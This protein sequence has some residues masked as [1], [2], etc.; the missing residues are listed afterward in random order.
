VKESLTDMNKKLSIFDTKILVVRSEI[1]KVLQV[2]QQR[3]KVTHIFSQQETGIDVTY[4]RDKLFK[5]YCDQNLIT[6][7]ESVSNGV[8]RGLQNRDTWNTM[9]ENYM[10]ESILEFKPKKKQL[11]NLGEIKQIGYQFLIPKLET[12]KNNQFQKGGTEEGL[13]Y[14]N[15]FFESKKNSDPANIFVPHNSNYTGGRISPYLA[16]GNLSTREVWNVA[17]KVLAKSNHSEAIESFMKRLKWQAHFIQKFEMEERIQ[18]KSINAAFEHIDKPTFE[19]LQNAWK[20]GKTGVPLVDAAMRCLVKTGYVNYKMRALL[21]SFFTHYLWQP[22]QDASKHLSRSFLDFEPGIHF[23]Q[24]QMQ[25]CETGVNP[26][27]LQNPIE[28]GKKYDPQG[29]FIKKWLPELSNLPV[30]FVHEPFKMTAVDQYMEN[31]KTGVDYPYPIINIQEA[32]NN[33]YEKMSAIRER[34]QTKIENDRIME[35]H[36]MSIIHDEYP[37]LESLITI[38]SNAS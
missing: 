31:F 1:I 12:K 32:E 36:D 4:E 29:L 30:K 21:A 3:F 27:K 7:V 28:V 14:L 18:Y 25:S 34:F 13:Q 20:I 22:W 5:R 37:I 26:I 16:W 9:W 17:K 10:Q 35:K 19:N 33:A 2:L 38:N 6:W 23:S 8:Q 24:I 11:F 15:A